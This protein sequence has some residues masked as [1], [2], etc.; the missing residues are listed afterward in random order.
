[1]SREEIKKALS[2]IFTEPGEVHE[3]RMLPKGK[4]NVM[5]GYFDDIDKC[6]DACFKMDGIPEGIY[7]T[8]NPCKPELLARAC[9][10][11]E[12]QKNSKTF[13]VNKIHDLDTS[14]YFLYFSNFRLGQL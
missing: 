12:P 13:I 11:I 5:S 10:R 6:V 14:K 4:D 2:L 9:N 7:I 8:I 3:I 1:M